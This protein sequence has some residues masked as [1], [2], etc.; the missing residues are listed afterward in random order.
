[1]SRVAISR[2]LVVGI[3]AAEVDKLF[4]DRNPAG[5][6]LGDSSLLTP[7]FWTFLS[8]VKEVVSRGFQKFYN[9]RKIRFTSPEIRLTQ[10]NTPAPTRT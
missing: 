3:Q 9:R 5:Q 2:Q 1:M 8:A 10:L 7:P 4:D 6:Q